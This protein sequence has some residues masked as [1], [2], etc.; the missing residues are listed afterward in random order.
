MDVDVE[1]FAVAVHWHVGRIGSSLDG[2][3]DLATDPVN[4]DD[5]GPVLSER[6]VGVGGAG[7]GEPVRGALGPHQAAGARPAGDGE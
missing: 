6:V 7:D 4:T 3:E 5:W 2:V 1:R